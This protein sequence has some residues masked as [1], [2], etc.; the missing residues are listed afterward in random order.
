MASLD[1][2]YFDPQNSSYQFFKTNCDTI[3][4]FKVIDKK[5]NV[6][7]LDTYK[8]HAYKNAKQYLCFWLCNGPKT[9]KCDDVTFLKCN[10]WRF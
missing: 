6:C 2:F 8:Q 5:R 9:G 3:Q 1:F 7:D 10:F 4:S